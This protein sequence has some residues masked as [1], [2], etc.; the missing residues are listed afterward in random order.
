MPAWHYGRTRLYV[1]LNFKL[2]RYLN[3]WYNFARINSAVKMAP[4]MVAGLSKTLWDV[5]DIVK[6]VENYEAQKRMAA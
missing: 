3:R 5:A 2:M 4:A 6:L 1:A